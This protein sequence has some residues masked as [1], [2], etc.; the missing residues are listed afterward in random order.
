M[1]NSTTNNSFFEK[2]KIV[3]LNHDEIGWL[4]HIVIN[5]TKTYIYSKTEN[6]LIDIPNIDITNYQTDDQ[7]PEGLVKTAACHFVFKYLENRSDWITNPESILQ[8]PEWLERELTQLFGS[9]HKTLPRYD[10]L[11]FYS[12]LPA[13]HDLSA[14][15]KLD[16]NQTVH[17]EKFKNGTSKPETNYEIL[18]R[19]YVAH[20]TF[21]SALVLSKN[22]YWEGIRLAKRPYALGHKESL[23][24][25][26]READSLREKLQ[27]RAPEECVQLWNQLTEIDGYFY[28]D[29]EI[30]ES[31]PYNISDLTPEF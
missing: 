5:K 4:A 11:Y 25:L 27:K 26:A 23:Q 8:L 9:E 13:L 18:W 16:K 30:S 28:L 31:E 29:D 6:R 1:P 22:S 24:F 20:Q 17:F 3:T 21:K 19:K 12:I 7:A 10:A 15:F 2:N 14:E